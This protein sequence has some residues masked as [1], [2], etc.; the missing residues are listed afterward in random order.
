MLNT[1]E[2]LNQLDTNL[3]VNKVDDEVATTYSG[4]RVYHTANPLD[5][6]IILYKNPGFT[7]KALGIKAT[8]VGQGDSNIGFTRGK[9]NGFNDTISSFIIKRGKWALYQAYKY[10]G[11]A[12]MY[13]TSQSRL[14]S[15]IDNQLTSIKRVG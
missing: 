12:G 6:D 10:G 9:L 11:Y 15:A 3:A 2:Y 5:G 4:G 13:S 8:V 1:K 14:P 7:G